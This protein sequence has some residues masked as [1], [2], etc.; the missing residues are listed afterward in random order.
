MKKLKILFSVIFFLIINFNLFSQDCHYG[1]FPINLN[2]SSHL[3][4]IHFPSANTGYIAGWW[5]EIIK[6]TNGGNNWFHLTNTPVIDIQCVF[7]INNLTGWVSGGAG[8]ISKTTDGGVTWTAQQSGTSGILYIVYFKDQN[9]GWISADYG[10][11]L[12]STNGGQNWISKPSGTTVN[13]TSVYFYNNLTGWITGDNGKILKSTDGGENWFSLNSGVST[14]VGKLFFVNANTGWVSGDYGKILK[15]TNGGTNWAQQQSWTNLWL[16]SPFFINAY[17]GWI[18]G[19]DG[20]IIKTTNGGNCW[21]PQISSTGND[22]RA[23]Y[24]LNANTGFTVGFYGTVVKTVTGGFRFPCPHSPV[25]GTTNVSLTPGLDWE[26]YTGISNYTIQISANQNFSNFVDTAN[27]NINSYTVPNGKLQGLTSYYWRVRGNGSTGPTDWSDVWSF[28]TMNS[29]GI[30]YISSVIP[31]DFKL[32]SNYPNPFNPATK[33]KFDLP[34]KAFTSLIVF[35][36]LGRTLET[37]VNTELKEG[38]YE[39]TWNASKY[40]S[41]VYFVRIVSDKFVETRK[42]LLIK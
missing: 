24:F 23:N 42:M 10:K 22:F 32:Y 5:N 16:I 11:I 31:N 4:S 1:W 25:N 14:N 36:A 37:L 19:V 35:D 2:T 29:I 40:N 33:I 28:T 21:I 34:K 17:T 38:S 30:N 3:H 13:L 18:A 20:K 9:N 41:G 26:N 8:R 39:F 15:T 27:I 7:F 12:K 6:S